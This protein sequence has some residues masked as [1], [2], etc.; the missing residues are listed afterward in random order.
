V[1]DIDGDGQ[2]NV[3]VGSRNR[4]LYAF[5]PD[6]SLTPGFPIDC[7]DK[8]F[9]SPWVGDLDGD[10]RTDIVVGANNGIHR[11]CNIGKLGAAPW[12]MFRRDTGHTGAVGN[13]D[14]S[15]STQR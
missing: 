1:A 4:R 9:S 11:I 8:I 3:I 6:G 15:R 5:S 14:S 10:G 2:L 12:P 13:F 7:G